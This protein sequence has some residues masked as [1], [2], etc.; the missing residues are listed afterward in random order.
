MSGKLPVAD[1]GTQKT[2]WSASRNHDSRARVAD[3]T[4]GRAVVLEDGACT[5]A[6]LEFA[7]ALE[8]AASNTHKRATAFFICVA[9]LTDA[10]SC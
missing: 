3:S 6:T 4:V 8:H 5:G 1:F 9:I 2:T 7:G 10:E